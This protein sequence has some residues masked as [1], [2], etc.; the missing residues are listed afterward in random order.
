MDTLRLLAAVSVIFS[1]SFPI[2]EGNEAREPFVRLLG[3]GNILGVYGV[4]VFFILSGFL[5][6]RSFVGRKST[7]R[8]L[9][10][11]CLRIFPA[12]AVCLLLLTF[13]LGPALTDLSLL[14]YFGARATWKFLVTGL[15]LVNRGDSALPG[16]V[17]ST[18]N[19]GSLI[20]GCLWTLG[21]EFA[22]YLAVLL[23]G[24]VRLLRPSVL[25]ALLALAIWTRWTGR[26]DALGY[27][28][29]YFAA[30]ALTFFLL[31][32]GRL[33]SWVLWLCALGLLAGVL[34]QQLDI[35][36]AV[37]G[38]PLIITLG[39]RA[40]TWFGVGARYGDVSYGMYL[41][42]WPIQEVWTRVLGDSATWWSVFALSLPFAGL[43][44]FVSFHLLEKRALAKAGSVFLRPSDARMFKGPAHARLSRRR[45]G[46]ARS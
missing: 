15:L 27:L 42:G 45:P 30:G 31:Q 9:A 43:C 13:V 4:Y 19:Y 41:Y 16:V 23:L 17:F 3:P 35:T 33:R 11:R 18:N 40:P 21:A 39:I 37:C 38:A 26:G 7:L 14:Q 1:H 36:F 5:I 25:V 29:L 22:C 6:T 2:V 34:V 44:G 12:L 28:A 8:Y 24:V 10:S 46:P 20:N 32:R